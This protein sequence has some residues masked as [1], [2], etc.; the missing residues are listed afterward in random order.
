MCTYTPAETRSFAS[1]FVCASLSFSLFFN[2]D[3]CVSLSEER[4]ESRER[5]SNV[6]EKSQSALCCIRGGR[7]SLAFSLS[8]VLHSAR[9]RKERGPSISSASSRVRKKYRAGYLCF[10]HSVFSYIKDLLFDSKFFKCMY[11]RVAEERDEVRKQIQFILRSKQRMSNHHFRCRKE[12][13]HRV[14]PV[15]IHL[16]SYGSQQQRVPESR[17]RHRRHESKKIN[18]DIQREREGNLPS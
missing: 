16:P 11:S 15:Y 6:R 2:V 12:K 17:T 5:H 1:L 4:R 18:R 13:Y 14:H 9:K 7:C 10:L 3:I 8:A